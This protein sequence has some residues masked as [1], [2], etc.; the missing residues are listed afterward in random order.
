MEPRKHDGA[1]E[2]MQALGALVREDLSLSPLAC[3]VV[4]TDL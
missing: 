2:T 1:G 3:V 4:H